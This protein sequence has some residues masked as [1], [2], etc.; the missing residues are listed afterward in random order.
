MF[1]PRNAMRHSRGNIVIWKMAWRN[2][3]RSKR[4]TIITLASI[5]FGLFLALT[6]T[7]FSDGSYG[8]LI[9]SAALVGA[10][11]VTLEPVGY[12]K[13]QNIEK[14]I[15]GV[16]EMVAAIKAR[17]D[18][19]FVSA[20]IVGQAMAATAEDSSGVGFV[21]IDP[22]DAKGQLFMLN[23]IVEGN[24]N[25]PCD[26]SVI[27]IGAGLA[28]K[29]GVKLR[30]RIVI[31]TTD[32]SGE[33]VSGLYRVGAIF[34]TGSDS[35]DK[36]SIIVPIDSMRKLIGY[37]HEDASQIAV[38]INDQRKSKQVAGEL[39]DLAKKHGGASFP[40]FDVIPTFAAFI[41]ID[42]MNNYFTQILIFL[43]IAAG[44]FNTLLMSVLERFREFGIMI[45]MGLTPYRLWRLILAEAFFLAAVGI[46]AG[47]VFTAP[48]FYYLHTHGLDLSGLFGKKLS[49]AGIMM[50][51]VLYTALFIDHALIIICGVFLLVLVTG[52]YPAVIAAKTRPVDVIKTL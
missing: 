45:A 49:L 18:V 38:L 7:G 6:F 40:W 48:L 33:V 22:N 43:I 20:R 39:S 36:Y 10:G 26:A 8:K 47:I 13:H 4:R 27:V 16:S 12:R 17:P 1:Q 32:K 19:R 41:K 2:L 9:D 37:G 23:H 24:F 14:F 21:A 5:V 52:I 46:V 31:T 51:P 28:K 30:S 3:W 42:N 11:H 44:I 15:S 29:L 35:V 34:K 25:I 50:S